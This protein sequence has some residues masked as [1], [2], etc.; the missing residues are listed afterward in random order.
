MFLTAYIMWWV[1]LGPLSSHELAQNQMFSLWSNGTIE[2]S[3]KAQFGVE[4]SLCGSFLSPPEAL[5]DSI[6]TALVTALASIKLSCPKHTLGL[7]TQY[8]T[9]MILDS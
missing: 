1:R 4:H 7:V 6:N 8:H 9:T 5:Y 3:S 2:P